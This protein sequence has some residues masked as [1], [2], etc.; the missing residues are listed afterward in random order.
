MPVAVLGTGDV[1][2]NNKATIPKKLKIEI[3]TETQAITVQC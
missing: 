3:G 1:M 2:V